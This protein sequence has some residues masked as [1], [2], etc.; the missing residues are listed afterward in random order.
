MFLYPGAAKCA[1][2]HYKAVDCGWKLT[3]DPDRDQTKTQETLKL[4]EQFLVDHPKSEYLEE[5]TKLTT[6]NAEKNS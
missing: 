4:A 5:V 3:L 2:A 1:Y 6:L